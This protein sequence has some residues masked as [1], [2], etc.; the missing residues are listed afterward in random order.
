MMSR[1][2][3]TLELG[4][5]LMIFSGNALA[6]EI[7][8]AA[9]SDL[10]FPMKEIIASFEKKTGH[11]VKLTLGSSGNFQAQI[12]NGAPFDVFMSA[13]ID[14]IRQLEKLKLVDSGT[15]HVYAIGR[16]VIW[17]PNRSPIDV[18]RLGIESLLHQSA[19]KVAIANPAHAPYGRAAVAAM[20]HFRVY[21][22]VKPHLVLGENIA[23]AAQF[24]S[25]GAADIG[26]IAL[27]LAISDPMHAAGRYWEIPLDSYP[28]M[29][30]GM[31]ILTQARKAGHYEAAK[32][33]H[34]WIATEDSRAV[35]EKYGFF[36]PEPARR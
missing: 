22:R 8:V 34:D 10:S 17:S 16:I 14:N 28:R 6:S 18:S 25:S 29:E 19:K 3:M 35:L 27:S 1:M 32:A 15:V 11:T 36:L 9:A 33:F 2:R 26:I 24:L 31:A 7:L 23:Q 21:D 30:Q 12:T 4:L 13:D 5:V 20:E